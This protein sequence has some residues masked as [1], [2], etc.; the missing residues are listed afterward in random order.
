MVVGANTFTAQDL[1]D[2]FVEVKRGD[3]NRLADDVAFK[4]FEGLYIT[5]RP[6][7]DY[8]QDYPYIIN[9]AFTDDVLYFHRD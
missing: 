4:I 9:D 3:P 5:H 2:R 1:Y 8:H 7:V 6:G